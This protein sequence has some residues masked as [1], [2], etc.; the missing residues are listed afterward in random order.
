MQIQNSFLF[1]LFLFLAGTVSG[2]AQTRSEKRGIAYDIKDIKDVKTLA[3]GV[4][5]YYNWA[6]SPANTLVS[7]AARVY[8]MD[9]IPMT[10]NGNIQKETL[11]NFLQS[12]PHVNY[13]LAFNEPNFTEQARMTPSEAAA[14]WPELEAV[15][16]EFGLKI[17]GPAVNFAP[18]NGGAVTENGVEYTDPVK[19]LDDFF[20]ACPDCR[21]DYIAVHCY[22]NYVSALEWY[23]GLFKKYGKPI[24][25]TEFCAWENGV[26]DLWQRN[27]IAESVHY[28][29]SDPDVFRY[30]WFI[31][32]WG[33]TNSYPYMQLLEDA[34]GVL[35]EKGKIYLNMSS[36]DPEYYFSV[37]DTIP[38][39]HYWSASRTIH[40]Q[41]S[42]D[43]TG[44]LNVCDFTSGKWVEYNVDIP[45][46][47]QYNLYFRMAAN[48]ISQIDILINQSV[49]KTMHIESSGGLNRWMTHTITMPLKA[50]KQTIRLQL[51]QGEAALNW[52]RVCPVDHSAI[53]KNRISSVDAYPNPVDDVLWLDSDLPISHV[54]LQDMSGRIALEATHVD[55]L[56]MSGLSNGLYLLEI[57]NSNEEK[58]I[59]KVIKRTF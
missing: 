20:A 21:V 31:G 5:W 52:M 29:E 25:L 45:A 12:N 42:S 30:S 7:G 3:E 16:D 50:G 47:N 56:D 38:A 4:S 15:A 35:T 34:P 2:H 8:G 6:H 59:V 27:F 39:E 10:W 11:R 32:R 19:Y 41:Q 1:I 22:M 49:A 58:S 14:K 9:F 54:I 44:Q 55:Q 33:K 28:L 46:D 40:L 26:T 36:F 13:I 43:N 23:I 37:N 24:W 17:V 51:Q 48:K 53:Q 57:K 18:G